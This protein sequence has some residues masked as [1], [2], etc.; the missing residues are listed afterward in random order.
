MARHEMSAAKIVVILIEIVCVKHELGLLS[1]IFVAFEQLRPCF[2]EHRLE[3]R[4]SLEWH[5]IAKGEWSSSFVLG[6]HL[7]GGWDVS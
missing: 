6:H 4:A 1:Q 3:F 5:L 7:R 2:L